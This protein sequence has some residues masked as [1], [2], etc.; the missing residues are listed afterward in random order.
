MELTEGR[1]ALILTP[2]NLTLEDVKRLEAYVEYLMK[3]AKEDH[4]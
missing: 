2:D 3:I 1:T 4:D